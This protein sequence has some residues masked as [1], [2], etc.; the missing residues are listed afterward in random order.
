MVIAGIL[1]RAIVRWCNDPPTFSLGSQAGRRG[2]SCGRVVRHY[3]GYCAWLDVY[4]R[5][6]MLELLNR[7]LLFRDDRFDEIADRNHAH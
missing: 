2:P 4:A 7:E 3:R 5:N 6:V 1:A